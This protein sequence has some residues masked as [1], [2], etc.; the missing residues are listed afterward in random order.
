MIPLADCL[1]IEDLRTRA[2]RALPRPIFSYMD[3]GAESQ[4]TMARNTSGFD[5]VAIIPRV[6]KDVSAPDTRVTVLGAKLAWPLICAPTGASR[7]YHPEGEGAVA[8]A[9]ASSGVLYSLSTMATASLE[10]VARIGAAPKLFQLY[11]FKDRGVTRA[12]IERAKAAGYCGLC[13]TVDAAARGKREA[14]LRS[15]MGIPLRL[16]SSGYLSFAMH[17]GWLLGQVRKG[18]MAMANFSAFTGRDDIV[19][20]AKFV[21]AQLDASVTWKDIDQFAALWDGPMALKGVVHTDDAQAAMGSG[22]TALIVSNHGG[23]QL[24]GSVAA[25]DALPAIVEAAGEKLE[26]ILDGGIR[27]GVHIRKALGLGAKACMIGR[28]YL[29]GLAAGGEAGVA[30]ALAIL[31]E[32]FVSAMRLTGCAEL[33]S[34]SAGDMRSRRG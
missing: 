24:D 8:R 30:R 17:P 33:D 15:G 27:R 1:N 2:R 25:I 11:V 14:E 12:L 6:L 18:P 4:W 28:P 26:I 22:A 19:E 21:G 23:R 7:F 9:A 20:H 16:K 5:D 3:G 32:E 29:Y 31:S 13:L 10:E 34:I